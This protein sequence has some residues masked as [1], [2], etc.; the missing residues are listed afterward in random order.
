MMSND[1]S[2]QIVPQMEAPADD[3]SFNRDVCEVTNDNDNANDTADDIGTTA[4]RQVLDH[5]TARQT[6]LDKPLS[7]SSSEQHNLQTAVQLGSMTADVANCADE[8]SA[9]MDEYDVGSISGVETQIQM[10]D[11]EKLWGPSIVGTSSRP[12]STGGSSFRSYNTGPSKDDT[13]VGGR[14]HSSKSNQEGSGRLHTS[15][16]QGSFSKMRNF[17]TGSFSALGTSMGGDDGARSQRS[18]SRQQMDP[19]ATRLTESDYPNMMQDEDD[20]DEYSSAASSA[21]SSHRNGGGELSASYD[22]A[23]YDLHAEQLAK[24]SASSRSSTRGRRGGRMWRGDSANDG[25]DRNAR[26]GTKQ[27]SRRT[28]YNSAYTNAYTASSYATGGATDDAHCVNTGRKQQHDVDEHDI[29]SGG[30]GSLLER[31]NRATSNRTNTS[32]RSATNSSSRYAAGSQQQQRGAPG[33]SLAAAAA[34]ASEYSHSILQSTRSTLSTVTGSATSDVNS[35]MRKNGTNNGKV[36]DWTDAMATTTKI[37]GQKARRRREMERMC[38]RRWFVPVILI[39]LILLALLL[40]Y[41]KLR[42]RDRHNHGDDI[43]LSDGGGRGGADSGVTGDE[44]TNGSIIG[45]EGVFNLSG[46][47]VIEAFESPTISPAPTPTEQG[48][49]VNAITHTIPG[50]GADTGDREYGS[51]TGTEFTF[52]SDVTFGDD[53][54]GAEGLVASDASKVDLSWQFD[55][56]TNDEDDG[57][58][59]VKKSSIT[60]D[61]ETKETSTVVEEITTNSLVLSSTED[62]SETSKK[63]SASLQF[64][65]S[66]E[67]VVDEEGRPLDAEGNVITIVSE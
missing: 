61:G 39:I 22:D 46:G 41:A 37:P 2:I 17:L 65:P 62:G 60:I 28:S 55:R 31:V 1:D 25:T 53:K 26:R 19:P 7:S 56:P 47:D 29:E 38:R 13:G 18:S 42:I 15:T 4:V 33:V 57:D 8:L 48:K 34:L 14:L 12:T 49:N 67:P 5:A 45:G 30:D 50:V 35:S 16:S 66:G 24:L 3:D 11:R 64:L 32:Q 59:D 40:H 21:A 10:L 20:D 6:A 51:E 27:M 54:D 44:G 23:E 58:N 52:G 43:S 63:L 36:L 9:V